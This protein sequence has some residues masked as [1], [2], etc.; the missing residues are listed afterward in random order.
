M[1]LEIRW[2]EDLLALEQE[3]SISQAA[4]IGMLLSLP[5]H[6]EFKI[7]KMHWVSKSSIDIVKILI[8]LK[9]DKFLASAKNIQNQLH[10]NNKIFRKRI[11]N[12]ELT[13]KFAVSHSLITQFFPRFIHELSKI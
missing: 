2:I 13:V 12:N 9:R 6:V 1:T 5:S 10:Y 4:E 8:S 11:K 3:K 7:L